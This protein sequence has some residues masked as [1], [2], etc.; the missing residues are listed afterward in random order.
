MLVN[1]LIERGKTSGR[2]D[3]KEATIVHRFQV[4]KSES[5]PVI[6]LYEPFNVI[7][8]VDC[9]GSIK[10]VYERTLRALRPEVF[11]IVGSTLSGKKSISSHL[12]Q[13]YCAVVIDINSIDKK[14]VKNK[15]VPIEDDYELAEAVITALQGLQHDYRAIVIGFPRTR[16]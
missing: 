6:K 16:A 2:A 14:L 1:R 9:L 3:D 10:D 11:F 8:S 12:A 4:Y 7:R 5:V 13:K 15:W